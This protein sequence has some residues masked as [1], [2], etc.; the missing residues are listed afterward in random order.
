MRRALHS[1]FPIWQLWPSRIPRQTIRS[2]LHPGSRTQRSLP[3]QAFRPR[4]SSAA[5][6]TS[7]TAIPPHNETSTASSP[8]S[9]SDLPT[10]AV[11]PSPPSAFPETSSEAF[12]EPI[13]RPSYQLTFTCKPCL[14]RSTHDVSKQG[15]HNGTVLITCPKCKNKH[16]ISDHLKV[17][18]LPARTVTALRHDVKRGKRAFG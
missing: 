4:T 9:S 15:Y 12:A 13:K 6:T 8:S 18:L 16:V 5:F 14:E 11:P 3:L 17:S 1:S 2:S 10:P 7:P